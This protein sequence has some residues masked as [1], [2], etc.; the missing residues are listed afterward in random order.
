MILSSQSLVRISTVR[1]SKNEDEDVC[2][3]SQISA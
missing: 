1:D 3:S 2:L